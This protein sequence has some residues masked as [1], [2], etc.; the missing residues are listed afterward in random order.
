VA[1][2]VRSIVRCSATRRIPS[3]ILAK[4]SRPRISYHLPSHR[5]A[6]ST[7]TSSL[8]ATAANGSPPASILGIF[9]NEL[10]KI[11]PK[12]EIHGSQ[13]Q[14]LRSP[15]EFYDTLKVRLLVTMRYWKMEGEKKLIEEVGENTESRKTDFLIN[16]VYRKNRT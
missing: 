7:S 5:T 9:T 4:S 16:F 14:I 3:G 2:I 13:I 11:A 8:S 12:F 1:M 6:Y 15:A 10:D